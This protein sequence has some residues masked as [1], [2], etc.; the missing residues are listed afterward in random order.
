MSKG[1]L[2]YYIDQFEKLHRGPNW[3][4]ED[5]GKKLNLV[6]KELAFRKP[7]PYL[8]SIAEVLSHLVE[9]RKELYRRFLHGGSAALTDASE[10]NWISNDEL[11]RRG[12]ASLRTEFEKSQ[13]GIVELLKERDDTFLGEIWTEGQTY[14]Y[15]LQGLIEHDAYHLGQIGL[16][17]KIITHY[18][19]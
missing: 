11:A 15:L 6:S 1:V 5:F 14:S 19:H 10:N 2:T 16:I 17:Y 12:W 3:L 8:H 9:W 4:D 7:F 18:G 13:R